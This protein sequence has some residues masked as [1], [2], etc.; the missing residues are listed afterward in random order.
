MQQLDKIYEKISASYFAFIGLIV[1]FIGLVPAILVHPDFNFFVTHISYL[2]TPSNPLY[3]LFNICWF[4]TAVFIILFFIGFNR[5]LQKRNIGS[6]GSKIACILGILSAIGIMGMAI[7]NSDTIYLVHLMFELLFF[8]TGILYLFLY[9]YLEWRSSEFPK[10]QA[11]FNI[12]VVIFF[13]LYLVLLILN[14]V[15]H[16]L[17]PEAESLTEWLFLFAN[18]FWFFENGI[19]MLKKK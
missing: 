3:I 18:L 7:F 10:S 9:T 5:Y 19:Y 8:V 4:I 16:G 6:K 14:R 15:I 12:L 17:T 11:I 2:G 13:L 1:F